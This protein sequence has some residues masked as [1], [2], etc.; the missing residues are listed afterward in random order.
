MFYLPHLSQ[1]HL[2]TALNLFQ[3]C[4]LHCWLTSTFMWFSDSEVSALRQTTLSI[5]TV[6]ELLTSDSSLAPLVPGNT[7]YLLSLAQVSLSA[8]VDCP[9]LWRGVEQRQQLLDSLLCSPL[10]EVREL[11]LE[12]IL[13][14]LHEEEGDEAKRRPLWLNETTVSDLTNMA[15]QER[16]QQCLAKVRHTQSHKSTSV[17]LMCL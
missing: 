16:H 11:A 7:Q 15:V 12:C 1:V 14:K 2:P 9:D 5:L 10:Y 4:H 8:S 3:S 13:R 6:S 17:F